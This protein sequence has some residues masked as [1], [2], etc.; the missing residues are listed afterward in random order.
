MDTSL[1]EEEN[2]DEMD[3]FVSCTGFDEENLML[4]LMA[5]QRGVEDVISKF[6]REGYRELIEKIGIDMALNPLNIVAS[7]ILR[8][9]QG[10]K[11]IISSLLIQGQAEIMEIIATDDMKLTNI[12]LKDLQLPD[13]VLIAGIHRGQEVIIPNGFT[14]IQKDDKVIIFCL[15][16]DIAELE[17]LFRRKRHFL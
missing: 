8:Y 15:L 1:L 2:I 14:E 13:G 16:N 17:K 3:A 7:T 9:I 11:K 12:P 5:K 10:E 4:A 6:S